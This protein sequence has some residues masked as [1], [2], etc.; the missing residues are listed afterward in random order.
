MLLGMVTFLL[1]LPATQHAFLTYDDQQYVTENPHVS[2]GLTREGFSW[3][4]GFHAANWHPLTWLSH[5]L[6]CQIYGLNPAGHHLTS[7][8]I[9][10][11]TTALF[12]L[13]LESMTGATWR[14][15]AVAALFGWHPLHVE[16]VA[17]VA[18]RKDVLSAFFFVCA[19]GAYVRHVESKVQSPNPQYSVFSI[20]NAWYGAALL[21]F[22][23][24]LMSKPMVVTLP[25][26]LLLLDY[27]P[28]SRVSG[29]D[30]K[31]VQSPKSKVQSQE[32]VA[33]WS[34][35]PVAPWSRLIA[36]KIPFF[37]L[38]GVACVLTVLAQ[39]QGSAIVSKAG[40]PMGQ[41]IAHAI[42][43]YAHYLGATFVPINL[44]VYY[45]YETV[46]PAAHLLLAALILLSVSFVTFRLRKG[47]PWLVTGWL[48]FLGMLVPVIGLVQ[49]GDQAWAD[50]YTYLPSV[51]LFISVIWMLSEA[52]TKKLQTTNF[53][54]QRIFK[55]Q[56]SSFKVA[57]AGTGVLIALGL[58]IGTTGQLRYWKDT[59][60]Q[61]EHAAQVTRN[62]HMAITLLGSLLAK[63]GKIEEA[64]HNY[65]TALQIKPG[66]PEAQFFMAN[67]LEQQGR[68]EEAIQHY[69]QVL[70][71]RPVQVQAHISLGAAL[72]RQTNNQEAISHYRIAVQLDPESAVAHNN[73]ARL[74]HTE[75]RLDEAI[76]HYQAALKYDPALAQAHN[77]LGTLLLQKGK[78]SEGTPHL[79]TALQLS[80]ENPETAMNLALALSQQEGWQEATAL[81]AKAAEK[82]RFDANAHY[83]F[84]L[85]LRHTQKIRQAMSEFASALLIQPDFADALGELAWVLATS[86]APE[87]RN[88][89]EAVRMAERAS[90]LTGQKDAR[91]LKTLAA[92]YAEAQRFQEASSTIQRAQEQAARIGDKALAA[93]CLRMA[94]AFKSGRSWTVNP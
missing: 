78:L 93:E 62:N 5:M 45:P 81:F 61:F 91:K 55:L 53:K 25:F 51:G 79:R 36:E 43:S 84:G 80:P 42:L 92:A 41:R 30:R 76:E 85:A 73:L 59:R 71:Y 63:E 40:L 77:N 28:L 6:D 23:L 67:A 19:I 21:L 89:T 86:A 60:T 56:A 72:A 68:M 3:A 17:W 15:A 50:R 70:W 31:A 52:I 12:F 75:G 82:I 1:F 24:G 26:V 14:S 57:L 74:L 37:V 13:V 47:M 38:S 83:Q 35:G 27:W 64:I 54:L 4:F 34:R 18:E 7:I 29:V 22:A 49:V 10:S 65:R 90:E 9:H 8:L 94:E 69:R 46:I 44:A 33:A 2:V 11:L 48:W 39:G 87:F 16:S 20:Q 66:Y 88:G 32:S 58:L